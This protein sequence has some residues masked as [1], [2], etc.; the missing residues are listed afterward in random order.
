MKYTLHDMTARE[1]K[2][3]NNTGDL[4]LTHNFT[5]GVCSDLRDLK[6][7]LTVTDLT[8]P[9]KSCILKTLFKFW[10][11]PPDFRKEVSECFQREVGFTPMCSIIWQYN[12]QNTKEHCMRDCLWNAEI[13]KL[14]NNIP[15][16]RSFLDKNYCDPDICP[17]KINGENAC[18]DF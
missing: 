10:L 7:F 8:H 17:Q 9:V 12:S 3:K 16:Q 14:P 11:S 2:S 6:V 1:A 18:A 13:L 5:C 4:Y 15:N